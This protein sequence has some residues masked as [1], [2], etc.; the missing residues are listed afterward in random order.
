MR[1]YFSLK[2]MGVRASLSMCPCDFRTQVPQDAAN[3]NHRP[4]QH[5]DVQP[6][7]VQ[8]PADYSDQRDSHKIQWHDQSGI[9]RPECVAQTI[10]RCESRRTDPDGRQDMARFEVPENAWI[11]TDERQWK[12]DYRHPI[13]N[14]ERRFGHG[15]LFGGDHGNGVAKC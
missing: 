10:V 3:N 8:C 12:L 4:Y 2:T 6:L 5:E 14:A 9:P 7:A 15:Q 1:G 11:T 13:Y